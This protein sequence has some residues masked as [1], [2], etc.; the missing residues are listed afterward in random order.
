MGQERRVSPRVLAILALVLVT[1]AAGLWLAFGGAREPSEQREPAHRA[2]G[3]RRG[4]AEG[5]G[6]VAGPSADDEREPGEASAKANGPHAAARA[7][8]SPDHN[9]HGALE[10]R[11]IDWSTRRGV[12]G[13][14]LA[15]VQ[16]GELHTVTSAAD[17]S[18]RFESPAPGRWTL[19]TTTAEGYLPYAPEL[20]QSAVSW[21]ALPQV[22]ID[23]ADLFL[24][25]AVDYRGR[26]VDG[27][28]QPVA[29]A[30]VELFGANAGERA[31]VGIE[32]QFRSDGEG[33]FEFHAP[34]FAVLE[35][36]HPDFEP[37]RA[38]VDEAVQISH[39]LTLT[40]GTA[41]AAGEGAITGRIL[42]AEGQPLADVE[43]RAEP[44][45]AKAELAVRGVLRAPLVLS[46]ADGSFSLGPLDDVDY[47]LVAHR[48]GR[49]QLRAGPHR[50]GDEVELRAE[51]GRSIRGKLIDESGE[52]VVAG[53]VA[54]L[55][56]TGPVER[57]AVASLSIFD[58]RGEFEFHELELGRYL[59]VAG[60]QGYARSPELVVDLEAEL[61]GEPVELVLGSGAS[62]YGRVVDA[63]SREPL[64]L[65]QV[66][67]TSVGGRDSVLPG[68]SST[69]TNAEGRF[70]IGAVDP[71]RRSLQIAAFGH[72]AKVISG[73]E[74]VAG[75]RH[76]PVE[77]ELQPL[78]EGERAKTELVGIG[79]AIGPA[80]G[81][82]QVIEVIAG[83]GAEAA[84][85]E[86]GDRI[87]AVDGESVVELGFEDAVQ[88]IRG[89]VGSTVRIEL[90]RASAKGEG[91][92]E[93]LEV[94][95][96]PIDY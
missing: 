59:L 72:D 14:E 8:V 87:V 13:A 52:T 93:T 32:G 38:L 56:V 90:R 18:Y 42:D 12:A 69:V 39:E 28:G 64:A 4:P 9:Y 61:P 73:L 54:L 5:S 68:H 65:A 66:A 23:H 78:V 25:P 70:E 11:I 22:R 89:Q 43:I 29:G 67:V 36:R 3:D 33:R 7:R 20:G 92:L 51:A 34:D 84:G 24:F 30:E 75:E 49:P 19:S 81:A 27:E 55:R 17:G 79:V 26:V 58:P 86:A 6:R 82:I 2:S 62:V 53:T 95:R 80:E 60:A 1:V 76:G 74:L 96:R 85:V 71:G 16:A 40:L 77:V 31:L 46:E 44:D 37:G 94:E 57:E 41:P 50:P 21:M 83:G 10:G 45:A 47:E 63:D 35:A 91:E 88:N 48:P 15:F